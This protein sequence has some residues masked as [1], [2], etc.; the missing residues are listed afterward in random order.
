MIQKKMNELVYVIFN[1]I[2]KRKITIR[3]LNN[4]KDFSSDVNGSLRIMKKK[5]EDIE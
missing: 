1:R 3:E 5:D 2:L 4:I